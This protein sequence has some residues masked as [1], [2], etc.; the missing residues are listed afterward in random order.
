MFADPFLRTWCTLLM[1]Q[2]IESTIMRDE[3]F[4]CVFKL[5]DSDAVCAVNMV[6]HLF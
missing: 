4:L 6:I 3:I 2:L 1:P 5:I